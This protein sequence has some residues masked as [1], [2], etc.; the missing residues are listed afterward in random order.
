MTG[1]EMARRCLNPDYRLLF[2]CEQDLTPPQKR[3][4]WRALHEVLQ[5]HCGERSQLRVLYRGY[6][7]A[8]KASAMASKEL[9]IPYEF[10]VPQDYEVL[11][12]AKPLLETADATHY[13]ESPDQR[14]HAVIFSADNISIVSTQDPRKLRRTPEP[15]K[16][17]LDKCFEHLRYPK[18][19]KPY[20]SL[21]HIN[22]NQ[23]DWSDRIA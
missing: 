19:K 10:H 16:G 2:I 4:T 6:D 8:E 18:E 14:D 13:Y 7:G 12:W 20:P 17:L 15:L 11:E 3:L 22:P 1:L 9:S 21:H 23:P 5:Y